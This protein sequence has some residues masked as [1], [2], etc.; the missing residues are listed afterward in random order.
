VKSGNSIAVKLWD[1]K[2]GFDMIANHF[3]EDI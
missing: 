2:S 3:M 1:Q